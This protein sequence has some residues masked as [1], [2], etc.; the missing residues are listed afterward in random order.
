[1]T[2]EHLPPR[3]TGNDA[4]VILFTESEDPSRVLLHE[5][6]DGHA[7]QSLCG[8]C[9]T[10]ASNRGLPQAY[11]A[12]NR[13]VI[14]WIHRAVHELCEDYGAAP[15]DIWSVYHTDGRA[16]ELCIDHGKGENLDGMNNLHPGRIARQVLGM[17]LAVQR[18]D[19]LLKEHPQL[20]AAYFSEESSSIAPFSLHVALADAGINY[21]SSAAMLATI[22]LTAAAAAA[23]ADSSS[24][25]RF[26]MVSFPPF[27]IC[28]VEGEMSPI[29]ATRIDHWFDQPTG[30]TFTKSMRKT[31]Y[32]IALHSE[33]VVRDLYVGRYEEGE[34]PA[35]LTRKP[36]S[37]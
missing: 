34:Q 20:A 19:V 37:L 11:T 25:I 24:D 28:L 26:W 31:A 9:N 27:L 2:E 1:M 36:R 4:E 3:A 5:F 14:A 16:K 8:T 17:L 29:T 35:V 21:L 23:M 6:R 12:W 32:P 33:P 15:E 13:D 30:K 10:G 18:T 7:L 22:P